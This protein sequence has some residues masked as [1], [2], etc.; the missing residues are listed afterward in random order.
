MNVKTAFTFQL[1]H[2]VPCVS[3]S[4]S[5]FNRICRSLRAGLG[6]A[7][8]LV[9]AAPALAATAPDL[10]TSATYGVLSSTYTNTTPG[11]TINGDLGYS[12][13]P[14][15]VPTV[16]GTTH[17][18]D[19]A[20]AQAG[21]DQGLALADLNSQSC[22]SL[23]AGAVALDTVDLGAGPGVFPPGC[24]SSGGAMDI[25]VSTTVTLNGTGVYIFRPGGALTTGADSAVVAAGGA[26]E[27]DLFWAPI[28]A[29]TL[30]ANTEFLGTII[31][32]AGITFGQFAN[33]SGRALA[34]G[35][36]VT[37]DA[38][39]ITV[40]T[41]PR[42][43][44]PVTA[45]G[46]VAIGKVFSPTAISPGGISTLTITL[47]NHNPGVATLTAV[48]TDTLPAGLV[49]APIPNATTSCGVGVPTAVAGTSTVSLPIGT[50]IPSGVPGTCSVTVDV[51]A[52]APG[53][54]LNTLPVGALVTD[55]GSNAALA[56]ATLNAFILP[57]ATGIPTLSEWAMILLV[58][59]LA[60][61]GF[62]AMRRQSW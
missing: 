51:T 58:S 5:G 45:P 20:Y 7:V 53:S 60:I 26:C 1:R 35:G 49:V 41:C 10:A 4:D 47:L 2:L 40:P 32:D 12:T 54:Y 3:R 22:T 15:V 34:Y 9:C 23:G 8:L 37:T 50:T 16:N 38:N 44:P 19:A 56:S 61:V 17:D 57:L 18:S 21:I 6:A 36:T 59:L 52:A 42:F 28:A 30:G 24:Y 25:T 31:D 48:L 13:G 27:S 46:D 43:I 11:T 55:L 39:T 33:L 29:T 62:S 14:A